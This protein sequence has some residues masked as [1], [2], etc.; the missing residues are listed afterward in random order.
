MKHVV[1]LASSR[2][3]PIASCRAVSCRIVSQA[4]KYLS[5]LRAC[6]E[7]LV[8]TVRERGQ[9][10]NLARDLEARSEQLLSRNTANNMDRIVKDLGQVKAENKQIIAKLKQA[11]VIK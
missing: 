6:F 8:S 5:D 11:G 10:E 4:Y 9:Q 2:P 1:N 3:P 7:G